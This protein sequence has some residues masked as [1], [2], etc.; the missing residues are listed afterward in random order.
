M[1]AATA[2][3]IGSTS[4]TLDG[5][6]ILEKRPPPDSATVA[7]QRDECEIGKL[8]HSSHADKT[9]ERVDNNVQRQKRSC[10]QIDEA[11][12]LSS[13]NQQQQ[14][15]NFPLDGD[16]TQLPKVSLP[17]K[18]V[19]DPV[20]TFVANAIEEQD[21]EN[22][23]ASPRKAYGALVDAFRFQKDPEMLGHIILALRTAANGNTLIL[24]TKPKH[25]RLMHNIVRLNPFTAA[26]KRKSPP[27]GGGGGGGAYALADAHLNLLMAI[28]SANSVFVIPIMLSLWKMITSCKDEP[29]WEM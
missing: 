25:A 5:I 27:R 24:V 11:M 17:P 26:A 23:G 12:L 20:Q 13:N 4:S 18:E 22:E 14:Q 8:Q 16:W 28:V 10:H 19:F 7:A 9:D 21:K 1:T 15:S 29:S 3:K 2:T 6:S